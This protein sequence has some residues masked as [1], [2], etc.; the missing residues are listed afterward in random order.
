MNKRSMLV[1]GAAALSGA[2][3]LAIIVKKRVVRGSGNVITQDRAVDSFNG[4]CLAAIPGSICVEQAEQASIRVEADDNLVDFIQTSVADG[5]LF[6]KM[7]SGGKLPM[8]SQRVVVRITGPHINHLRLDG[9]G[10]VEVKAIKADAFSIDI[11]GVGEIKAGPITAQ[12]VKVEFIGIGN[13]ELSG[14]A[15]E[16]EVLVN[17]IGKFNGAALGTEKTR[18]EINGIANVDVRVKDE[19][20]V[21]LDGKGKVTY[22]GNP[23]VTSNV[24]LPG[25]VIQ[26]PEPAEVVAP[27]AAKVEMPVT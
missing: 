13:C 24:D 27:P 3:A 26:A 9:K 16:Q 17:G 19:L 11:N 14:T 10:K 20:I 1:F 7:D 6:I 22:H 4:I 25:R 5:M 8:P 23:K 18:V 12:K 21:Q 2:V 15:V